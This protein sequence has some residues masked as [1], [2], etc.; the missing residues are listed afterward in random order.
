MPSLATLLDGVHLP[1]ALTPIVADGIE[2]NDSYLCLHTSTANPEVGLGL[3]DELERLGYEV[4]GISENEAVAQRGADT[5]SMRID[6]QPAETSV[7]GIR[8][9]PDAKHGDVVVGVV[10]A[11]PRPT[12]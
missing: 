1:A 12:A 4:M 11:G 10:G 6:A 8:R 9:Y 7:A 3:A 2:P 5:V